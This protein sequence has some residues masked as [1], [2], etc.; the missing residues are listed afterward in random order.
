MGEVDHVWEEEVR[1][2]PQ[3][4]PGDLKTNMLPS[5]VQ[6]TISL[7]EFQRL[8]NIVTSYENNRLRN[9]ERDSTKRKEK[10]LSEGRLWIGKG[11]QERFEFKN[12]K[13]IAVTSNEVGGKVRLRVV[14]PPA[15][16]PQSG[17]QQV[18]EIIGGYLESDE[19]IMREGI[20]KSELRERVIEYSVGVAPN[21]REEFH[22][23]VY[24]L[25]LSNIDP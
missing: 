2:H 15:T 13:R 5:N 18:V 8:Q 22:E 19:N 12:V 9:Y 16:L 17:I 11:A 6:V 23:R 24:E 1:L 14:Q 20:T 3:R 21:E 10:A 7:Q 4:Y 25:L